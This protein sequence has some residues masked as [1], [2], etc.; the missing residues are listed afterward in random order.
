MDFC[1]PIKSVSDQTKTTPIGPKKQF[2]TKLVDLLIKGKIV[3]EELLYQIN[4]ECKGEE[5]ACEQ[6][7]LNGGYLTEEQLGQMKAQAFG[8]QFINLRQEP[9]TDNDLALLPKSFAQAN[10]VVPLLKSGE[11]CLTF[12]DPGN[13]VLRR[14]LQKKFGSDGL[15]VVGGSFLAS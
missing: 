13:R 9:I 6:A 8:W 4:I 7:L 12:T 2:N 15:E 11:Q 3:T 1:T 10:G 14:L 5:E